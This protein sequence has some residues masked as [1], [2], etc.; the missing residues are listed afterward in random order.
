HPPFQVPALGEQQPYRLIRRTTMAHA[1]IYATDWCPYCAS[2]MRGLK[3]LDPSEYEVIDV[4]QDEEAGEWVK[5]V[6]D[7]NRIVPT[8]KFSDGTHA[9]NPPAA[10]VIAKIQD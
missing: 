8:V 10:E 9:T 7:G 3:D 6:N 5:S 2:L 4:D 1:T